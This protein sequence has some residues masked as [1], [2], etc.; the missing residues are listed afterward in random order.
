MRATAHLRGSRPSKSPVGPSATCQ[1]Q[2]RPISAL[3]IH[4]GQ[5]EHRHTASQVVEIFIMT[6]AHVGSYLPSTAL[7]QSHLQHGRMNNQTTFSS[8]QSACHDAT[9]IERN[10]RP[11]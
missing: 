8:P 11:R 3:H 2:N 7:C 6:R 10:P 1:H 9:V 5:H 4:R